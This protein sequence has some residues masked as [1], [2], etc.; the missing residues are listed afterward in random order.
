MLDL[1]SSKKESCNSMYI[2]L[3]SGEFPKSHKNVQVSIRVRL[4][5]GSF[6]DNCIKRGVGDSFSD[7]YTSLVY[8]SENT[9]RWNESVRIDL[10][11]DVFDR[12]HVFITYTNITALSV[13]PVVSLTSFIKEKTV[14]VGGV[15]AF[16]FLPLL[17]NTKIVIDDA[18]HKLALYKYDNGLSSPEM[19]LTEA[20]KNIVLFSKDFVSISSTLYST[21][22]TQHI[23]LYNL[24]EWRNV[25]PTSSFISTP[26][27]ES[28]LCN[29][30]KNFLFLQPNEIL[31]FLGALLPS[32][33]TMLNVTTSSNDLSGPLDG[34]ILSSLTHVLACIWD[35]P[36]YGVVWDGFV[37]ERLVAKAP[38]CWWSLSKSMLGLLDVGLGEFKSSGSCGVDLCSAIKAC[39]GLLECGIVSWNEYTDKEGMTGAIIL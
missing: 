27:N 26:Q 7:H 31:K 34:S 39:K 20:A 12:A 1:K 33:F 2:T 19:Y 21:L 38:R 25:K 3:V 24:L 32:L 29:I 18:V 4:A 5:D 36:E 6:V 9:P 8:K 37:R 23:H 14:D 16:S 22:K 35:N 15:F 11:S 17:Q 30:L 10:S 13:P 28:A